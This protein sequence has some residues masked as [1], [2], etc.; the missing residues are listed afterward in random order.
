MVCNL[1]ERAKHTTQHS[2]QC[3]TRGDHGA[4]Q[5]ALDSRVHDRAACCFYYR[6][7]TGHSCG[8]CRTASGRTRRSI[9]RR[10]DTVSAVCGVILADSA[11]ARLDIAHPA[12]VGCINVGN[13][14]RRGTIVPRGVFWCRL[15]RQHHEAPPAT[16][17]CWTACT[18]TS[19]APRCR[20]HDR[21]GPTT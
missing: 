2:A 17:A 10:S 8:A 11:A 9:C 20:L 12:P 1:A 4:C 14:A 19:Q 16:S 6:F 3:S 15:Q 21:V 7:A 13:Y 5:C 18:G